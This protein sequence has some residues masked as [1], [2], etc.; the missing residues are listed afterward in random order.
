MILPF[1]VLAELPLGLSG[2]IILL[3]LSNQ[4]LSIMSLI[5]L[6]MISGI[7]INNSILK[8]DAIQKNLQA[9]NPLLKAIIKGGHTRLNAI[10]MTSLTT[11][12]ALVPFAI[13]PGLGTELQ[14]PL[15]LAGV[16]G[17]SI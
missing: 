17:L 2:G 4:G 5:G 15:A 1:I 14:R 6:V 8:I 3:V 12:L 9:G 16:G 7:I 10:L 13:F 11:I